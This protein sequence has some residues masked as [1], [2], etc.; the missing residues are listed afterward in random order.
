MTWLARGGEAESTSLRK[1]GETSIWPPRQLM[2]VQLVAIE[3]MRIHQPRHKPKERYP[4]HK[5]PDLTGICRLWLKIWGG[6]H[7]EV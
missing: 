1:A 6:R 3:T 7:G 5:A 2:I 4:P